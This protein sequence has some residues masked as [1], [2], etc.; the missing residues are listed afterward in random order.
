MT[1]TDFPLRPLGE[2]AENHDA[3]RRPVKASDRRPGP[4]P[5]YGAQ[6][7][8]DH[9]EGYLFDGEFVLVAEDGENL[10]S[11]KEDVAL[12]ANGKFWVNNHAHILR[13]S[14]DAVTRFLLYAINQADISG[15]VTGSTIPKLSQGSLNRILLPC[16]AISIQKSIVDLLGALDDKIELKRRM[17]E[18]LEAIARAVFK[19]WFVDFGPSRAKM[20]L[21]APYL[22]P[23]IWALFPDRLDDEGKPERW[24]LSNIGEEVTVVGGSTPSTKEPAFWEGDYAWV[25]PKDLS[26]LS[27]PVLLSTERSITV[28][29][30]AQIGSGLLPIGTV[31]L[32]SRAPIGYLA[33]AEVPTAINQ[34][35]IAMVCDGAI[36]NIHAWLWTQASMDLILQHANGSTFQEI[37]KKNFRPLPITV[38]EA[39]VLRSFDAIVR[40]LFDQI[41][42]NEK[43]SRTL[44]AT[45]DLLLPKL[46]SGEIR[47]RDVEALIADAA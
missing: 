31:L 43:E 25:T 37:S 32:S 23:D 8:V 33:I 35:F 46:M 15:Y 18:T 7:I 10:R 2:I 6:G 29:G 3:K 16:P 19:D 39:S 38:A 40:P 36:S 21:H 24:Q 34:G 45:R 9:V 44:A 27:V 11:R 14:S 22:A 20:E 5:Y 1:V 4:Y 12:L 13:G 30:L 42:S 28:A 41:V 17:N 47:V 26:N